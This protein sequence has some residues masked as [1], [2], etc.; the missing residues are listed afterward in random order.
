MLDDD[1]QEG[2]TAW[3]PLPK[4]AGLTACTDAATIA[5]E[6]VVELVVE[7]VVAGELEGRTSDIDF[8]RQKSPK[9]K[10]HQ[11]PHAEEN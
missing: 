5:V 1:I 11:Y 8:G 7:V 3:R 9:S 4:P 10:V 6:V 2:R